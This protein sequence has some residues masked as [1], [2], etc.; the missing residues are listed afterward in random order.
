MQS[1]L[2]SFTVVLIGILKGGVHIPPVSVQAYI[3]SYRNT[4]RNR[5]SCR[6]NYSPKTFRISIAPSRVMLFEMTL[7][8]NSL[9]L[10]QLAKREY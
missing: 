1:L 9:L 4:M 5:N 6:N 10:H 2:M 7:G 8:F 3:Y